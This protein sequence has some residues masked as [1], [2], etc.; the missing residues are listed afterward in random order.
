[1]KSVAIAALL[2]V[3]AM[4]FVAA[5]GRD[6]HSRER[7]V[8]DGIVVDVTQGGSDHKSPTPR[9]NRIEVRLADGRDVA[10]TTGLPA[11][12]TKGSTIRVSERVTPWGQVWYTLAN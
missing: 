1:M 3:I 7:A 2:V 5:L 10:I 8:L 4:G 12:A 11:S 6:F 9:L